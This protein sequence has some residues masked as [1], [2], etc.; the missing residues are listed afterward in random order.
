MKIKKRR[1][2]AS[3]LQKKKQK[4][5]AAHKKIRQQSVDELL[6]WQEEKQ[7]KIKKLSRIRPSE[8]NVFHTVFDFGKIHSTQIDKHHMNKKL[9]HCKKK[10]I[11]ANLIIEQYS[12]ISLLQI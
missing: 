7:K 11:K 4:R 6:T 8:V 1:Q 12:L 2:L 3:S 9:N 5:I 10:E